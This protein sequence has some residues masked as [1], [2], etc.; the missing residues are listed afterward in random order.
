MIEILKEILDLISK[1]MDNNIKDDSYCKAIIDVQS[2]IIQ[3][4]TKTSTMLD[5]DDPVLEVPEIKI[6]MACGYVLWRVISKY[7]NI[8]NIKTYILSNNNNLLFVDFNKYT[9]NWN[10]SY[11][12][13]INTKYS[14]WD[15]SKKS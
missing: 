3:Y 4:I 8:D 13:N 12:M 10:Q 2:I 1:K 9:N 15:D 6:P 11:Y 14:I 5:Y 7:D